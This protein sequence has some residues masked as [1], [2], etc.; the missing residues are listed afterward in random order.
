MKEYVRRPG[1][2]KVCLPVRACW[3]CAYV[4]ALATTYC[5]PRYD[6]AA[7]GFHDFHVSLSSALPYRPGQSTTSARWK[8]VM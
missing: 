7:H 6:I 5:S 4:S 3:A 8:C 2:Q 1:V